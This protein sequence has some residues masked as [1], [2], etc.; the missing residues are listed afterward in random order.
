MSDLY[1]ACEHCVIAFQP[2]IVRLRGARASAQTDKTLVCQSLSVIV[3]S[4]IL[5]FVIVNPAMSQCAFSSPRM[6][7]YIYPCCGVTINHSGLTACPACCPTLRHPLWMD[8]IRAVDATLLSSGEQYRVVDLVYVAQG[9]TTELVSVLRGIYHSHALHF[10][11]RPS[12]T[13]NIAVIFVPM[14]DS[15]CR[16]CNVGCW[17]CIYSIG[18]RTVN[19]KYWKLEMSTKPDRLP[20]SWCLCVCVRYANIVLLLNRSLLS[21]F[22]K[23]VRSNWIVNAMCRMVS[24]RGRLLFFGNLTWGHESTALRNE[25]LLIAQPGNCACK[26]REEMRGFVLR[27]C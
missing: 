19:Y 3:L 6:W 12:I 8:A 16:H 17:N 10:S 7:S 4:I 23:Q 22:W 1:S 13:T 20:K 26:H 25:I 27:P 24:I 2:L 5:L 18:A 15:I 9:W 11:V 21:L 14:M